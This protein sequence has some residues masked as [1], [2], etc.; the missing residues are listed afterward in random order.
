MSVLRVGDLVGFAALFKWV[1]KNGG[2]PSMPKMSNGTE[3]G[4]AGIGSD[5][6][7][8]KESMARLN[9][10]ARELRTFREVDMAGIVLKPQLPI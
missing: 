4:G 2:L 7:F 5:K 9:E 3:V 8:R 10:F 6:K 1:K